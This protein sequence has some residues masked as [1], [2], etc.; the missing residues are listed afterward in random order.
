MSNLEKSNI[1]YFERE[2][3]HIQKR[4]KYNSE[5]PPEISKADWVVSAME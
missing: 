4:Y 1:I 5:I 3:I 2:S